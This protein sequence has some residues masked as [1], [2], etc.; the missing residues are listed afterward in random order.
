MEKY[1]EDINILG[2]HKL[3]G[4]AYN[5]PTTSQCLNGEWDFKLRDNVYDALEDAK[6]IGVDGLSSDS[7]SGGAFSPITVPG[8]W[9]LQGHGAPQYTNMVFPFAVN[10]PFVPTDNPTGVYTVQFKPEW[11]KIGDKDD[12][13]RIRFDGVDSA[14]YVFLNGKFVGFSLGSRNPAEFEI[15]GPLLPNRTNCLVCVVPQWSSGSYIEDQDQWWFSGIFRDVHLIGYPRTG[16]IE[17]FAIE[18]HSISDD[19]KSAIIKLEATIEHMSDVGVDLVWRIDQSYDTQVS[20]THISANEMCHSQ[21]FSG[22]ISLVTEVKNPQLWTAETPYLYS[23]EIELWNNG[24][25]LHTVN[26]HLGIRTVEIKGEDFLVNGKNV[27][28]K[29]TNR[30]DNDPWK[31][32]AVSEEDIKHDLKLMKKHNLN[33]VRC[34][35]YPSHPSLVYWADVYGLY[36]IDEA[37]LECH[38]FGTV[39][40]G[41]PVRS[42]EDYGKDRLSPKIPGSSQA[43]ASDNPM[44]KEAYLDRSKRMVYRDRNHPCVVMWSL[45]NESAFGSNHVEMY[46]WIK[47]RYPKWPV[48]YE[49]DRADT[50]MDVYSRMYVD[51]NYLNQVGR[52]KNQ[53]PFIM[54]EYG[55]AM[56]N[57]PGAL[58]EYME[59][60]YKYRRHHGGFIWEWA[61][62]GLVKTDPSSGRQFFAFGGDFDE[63]VHDGTFVMDGLC[64]SDHLPTPG[65]LQ[66]KHVYRPA[67]FEFAVH[68]Q[69]LHIKLVNLQDIVGFD[70]YYL[71]VDISVYPRKTPGPP[72]AP[73]WVQTTIYSNELGENSWNKID[74]PDDLIKLNQQEGNEI[75]A[76]A[77]LRLTEEKLWAEKNHEV[78]FGQYIFEKENNSSEITENHPHENKFKVKETNRSFTITTEKGGSTEVEISKATGKFLKIINS[79]GN[80]VVETGPELGFWRA[81]TDNDL[82]GDAKDWKSHH[83]GNFH[84]SLES[85]SVDLS[86]DSTT[87]KV[88][89]RSWSAPPVVQW[90]VASTTVYIFQLNH[91]NLEAVVKVNSLCKGYIPNTLPRVGLDFVLPESLKTVTWLGK[92]PGETYADSKT[93]NKIGWFE[94]QNYDLFTSYEVPQD[95]GNRSEVRWVT[96]GSKPYRNHGNSMGFLRG[97]NNYDRLSFISIDNDSLLN[98]ESQPWSPNELEKAAHSYELESYPVRNH[99]RVDFAV[100]GLGSA[101]CGP[102]V[103]DKYK[104]KT[105]DE[106]KYH[107]KFIVH[108]D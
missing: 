69:K 97:A 70:D 91:H 2:V 77:S 30:H 101:S 62:H 33:A 40:R 67:D 80:K 18:T 72:I 76:T 99:F 89:I 11:K 57:G 105:D 24:T 86:E 93:G 59:L 52:D 87:A 95:N 106:L 37:D 63:P 49:G 92:G 56:G 84:T 4:R 60:F 88:E 103:Q 107:A 83:L 90:G 65:L 45:G 15:S 43:Y 55:H 100:H 104:L 42:G 39:A 51:F 16:H 46:K 8:H 53:K 36:V 78:S 7:N 26:T 25:L 23:V 14:L 48:H 44:W 108:G 20:A 54:C 12:N 94:A 3:D 61:N 9:Q 31:G 75:V 28:F 102:G 32:R 85:L 71:V 41:K 73:H 29:G 21:R 38:G 1:I 79:N 19:T 66:L 22:T 13:Y 5:I 58:D 10:P 34:S 50:T 64:T 47:S 74:L 96:V 82:G 68:G 35:H 27:M 98:F 17:D 6:E 81:P